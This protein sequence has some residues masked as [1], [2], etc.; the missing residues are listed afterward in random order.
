[1]NQE[2]E[3]QY[4]NES[5]VNLGEVLWKLL[6][7]WKAVL[8]VALII[9][10][11]L[12]GFMAARI[13]KSA[14]AED[15]RPVSQEMT[16]RE[17]LETLPKDQRGLVSNAFQIKKKN[18]RLNEYI[19]TAPM[20]EIN[21]Y[22]AHELKTS[23]AVE[24]E[25]DKEVTLVQAY[26]EMIQSS[27]VCDKLR[28]AVKAEGE[29]KQF[30]ELMNF[31][32]PEE[33]GPGFFTCTIAMT[34]KMDVQVLQTALEEQMKEIHDLLEKKM[35]AHKLTNISDGEV[36]MYDQPL[37]TRQANIYTSLYNGFNQLNRLQEEFSTEQKTAFKNLTAEKE[38]TEGKDAGR[39]KTAKKSAF[40]PLYFIIGLILGALLYAAV[41]VLW[42]LLNGRVHDAGTMQHAGIRS[43]GEWY[44]TGCAR[45]GLTH[46]R[47]VYK[48]HHHGHLDR[49]FELNRIADSIE[50]AC[51]FKGASK[52][53]MI[54]GAV[55]TDGQQAFVSDLKEKLAAAGITVSDAIVCS[56]ED[57]TVS[58]RD[59]AQCDAA[60]LVLLGGAS[61]GRDVDTVIEKCNYYEKP[62]LGSIYL[63]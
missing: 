10:A 4:V 9:G 36:Y 5:S 53:L 27:D 11:L 55:L 18:D 21:P 31:V 45:G 26:V 23:W 30:R 49:E 22:N 7:S 62:M 12:A 16:D 15:G 35:G 58:D 42:M 43:F 20:M 56:K 25:G 8:L 52:L 3:K 50:S 17:I 57:A 1:M 47:G 59:L 38:E 44:D 19:D 33:D 51:G 41:L 37:A 60:A 39:E 54:A 29:V 48:K 63:G 46:D 32:F 34:S 2:Y 40:R 28:K 6:E 24:A 61:N 13:S 14:K